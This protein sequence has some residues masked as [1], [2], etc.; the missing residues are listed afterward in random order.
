MAMGFFSSLFVLTL[1]RD[2]L[3][4]GARLLLSGRTG[5]TLGSAQRA[6]DSGCRALHYLGRIDHRAAPAGNR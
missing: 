5:A 1:L 3:L 2:V 4:L 6:S